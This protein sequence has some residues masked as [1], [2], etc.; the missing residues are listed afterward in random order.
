MA[1]AKEKPIKYKIGTNVLTR[2]DGKHEAMVINASDSGDCYEITGPAVGAWVLM[3]KGTPVEKI[4]SAIAKQYDQPEKMVEREVLA[5][6]KK[7]TKY[8]LLVLK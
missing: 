4:V 2:V 6:I 5:F 3:T 1:M 8:K 7:M